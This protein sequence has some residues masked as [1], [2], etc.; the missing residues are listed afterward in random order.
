MISTDEQ[1]K[2][3]ITQIKQLEKAL[4]IVANTDG[5]YTQ[6]LVNDALYE[7]GYYYEEKEEE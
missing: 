3:L 2:T 6:Q 1:I 4:A 5:N 7:V